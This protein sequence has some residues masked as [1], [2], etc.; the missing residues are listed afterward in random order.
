M[1]ETKRLEQ[2]QAP[3]Y[4]ESEL[5][6]LV[7]VRDEEVAAMLEKQI[8]LDNSAKQSAT[9]C[10]LV[11]DFANED[12]AKKL[13]K[14]L[15]RYVWDVPVIASEVLRD[16]WVVYSSNGDWNQSVRNMETLRAKGVNDLWLVPSGS[17]KGV[18]SLGLFATAD[19][20]EKRLKALS[21]KSIE[22]ELIRR[23]KYRYGVKLIRSDGLSPI[24]DNLDGFKVGENI[25]IRKIAC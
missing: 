19:G 12:D 24:P 9:E 11:G 21:E 20:A 4:K 16:F 8:L 2:H 10:Y 6:T 5:E 22:A 17:S 18:I 23:K 13:S 15:S 25:S 7:L 1:V 14:V 3:L